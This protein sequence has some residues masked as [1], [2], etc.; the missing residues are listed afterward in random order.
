[1]VRIWVIRCE[2]VLMVLSGGLRSGRGSLSGTPR[3]ISRFYVWSSGSGFC[4]LILFP[5]LISGPSNINWNGSSGK[6]LNRTSPRCRGE[7]C[8]SGWGVRECLT[9]FLTVR[10]INF[11]LYLR[12]LLLKRPHVLYARWREMLRWM[13][14]SLILRLPLRSGRFSR[15]LD[16][17][18]P[19]YSAWIPRNSP[20]VFPPTI[21]LTFWTTLVASK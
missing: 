21:F 18:S 3:G 14:R 11:A 19:G 9:L 17:L 10:F 4:G 15:R 20:H 7:W 8:S 12:G 5:T 1:M 13:D 6:R 16:H 2:L